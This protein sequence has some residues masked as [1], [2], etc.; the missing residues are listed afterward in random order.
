MKPTA[1]QLITAAIAAAGRSNRVAQAF[2]IS[3]AAVSAWGR[4]G[5]IPADRI[6]GLCNM[7]GNAVRPEAIVEALGREAEES[8][9]LAADLATK[10]A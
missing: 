2:G 5:R 8:R 4:T 1:Q 9:R 10:G 3:E 6:A 7:G